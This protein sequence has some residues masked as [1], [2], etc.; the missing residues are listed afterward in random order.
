M[1]AS[2]RHVAANNTAPPLGD[3]AN[4]LLSGSRRI[5]ALMREAG[6]RRQPRIDLWRK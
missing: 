4:K 5:D 1:K 2:A 6:L 3:M